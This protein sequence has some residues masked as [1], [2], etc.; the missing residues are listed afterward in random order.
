[1]TSSAQTGNQRAA[2]DTLPSWNDGPAK[3]AIVGFVRATTDPSSPDF[4]REQ[5]RI[6]TFDQDGTLWVEHPM[7]A[8]LAFALYRLAELEPQHPGWKTAEPFKSALAC[9]M[10]AFAKFTMADLETLVAVE[11]AMEWKR[12]TGAANEQN[13]ARP[14]REARRGSAK[15]PLMQRII[16]IPQEPPHGFREFFSVT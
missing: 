16:G 3:A 6:A 12:S 14:R 10:A 11:S 8:Q 4:V 2:V 5:E 15:S 1:M 7:Y 9:D 13:R